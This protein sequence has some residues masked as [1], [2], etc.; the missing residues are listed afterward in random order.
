MNLSDIVV[1]INA[2]V[3]KELTGCPPNK[4]IAMNSKLGQRIIWVFLSP[5]YTTEPLKI[6]SDFLF[7]L[8]GNKWHRGC[9][10]MVAA[11]LP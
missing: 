7:D 11:A 9:S 6:K 1:W 5:L 3:M 10:R 2:I 8:Q 4:T